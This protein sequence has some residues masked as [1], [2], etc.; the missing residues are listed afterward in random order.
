[1]RQIAE[2]GPKRHQLGLILE[3]EKPAPLGFAWEDLL[4][5]N[6]TRKGAMTNCVFS[7][8]MQANIGYALV[9]TELQPGDQLVIDRPQG[10]TEA[11]LVDL[12]FL[13]PAG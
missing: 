8:R 12:P 4:D 3:G 10:R 11:R 5:Q 2:T 9:S 6:G 13:P 1:L 7:P